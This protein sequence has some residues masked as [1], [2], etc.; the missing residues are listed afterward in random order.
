MSRKPPK[1]SDMKKAKESSARR[2]ASSWGNSRI[3]TPYVPIRP[4]RILIVTEGRKT[5]P[6]YFGGF[7]KRINDRFHGDFVSVEVVGLGDNTVSLYRRARKIAADDVD[8]FTQVW[9]VYDKDSFP[10]GDFNRV[11]ELCESASD[12]ETSVHAAWSNES[13]ELWYILHFVLLESA[14]GRE[15]YVSKLT[16]LM[17]DAGLGR[18]SKNRPDMYEMLEGR[19]STAVANAEKLERMNAGKTPSASNPGTAVHKLVAELQ[20]YVGQTGR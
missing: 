9:V 19:M 11:V 4:E 10:S 14:L 1:H 8:G 16:E 5:E 20:S 3:E 13:F 2:L 17:E 18:Y 15:A 6:L 7:R 12:G